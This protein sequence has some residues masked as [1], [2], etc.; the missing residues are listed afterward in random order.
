M[1]PGCS[2]LRAP[3]GLSYFDVG[4][5]AVGSTTEFSEG[6]FVSSRKLI[7][8]SYCSAFLVIRVLFI[9]QPETEPVE[10]PFVN[11]QSMLR[12]ISYVQFVWINIKFDGPTQVGE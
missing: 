8:S 1:P 12:L 7:P 2:V 11:F 10:I 4:G 3:R 9:F 5:S 6:R